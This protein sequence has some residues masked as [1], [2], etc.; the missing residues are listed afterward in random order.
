M[1]ETKR[2][3]WLLQPPLVSFSCLF[4]FSLDAASIVFV[5]TWNNHSPNLRRRRPLRCYSRPRP[6]HR[7]RHR[8][9][10]L[11]TSRLVY[12]IHRRFPH[13]LRTRI[14]SI[15]GWFY[16]LYLSI[17][18][19]ELTFCHSSSSLTMFPLQVS[20]SFVFKPNKNVIRS[21][22]NEQ[23]SPIYN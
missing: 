10:N 14:V 5:D 9:H 18:V 2:L 23:F 6:R 21:S 12:S 8:H 20:F 16:S 22:R 17:V 19:R 15:F 3:W 4:S 11:R 1:I 7:R 13:R